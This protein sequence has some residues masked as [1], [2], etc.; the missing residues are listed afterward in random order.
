[1][2]Q[3]K[4]TNIN[5]FYAFY[6]TEHTN[7]MNRI[8]HFTGIALLALCFIAAMLFHEVNFFLFMPVAA[9]GFSW[10]GH[11]VFERNKPST[12]KYPFMSLLSDFIFFGDL[13]MG[14]QSFKAK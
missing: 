10:I 9:F 11:L 3:K 5:E 6:L 7:T 2:T 1:M 12:L 13:L 14:R 4:Y 8:L